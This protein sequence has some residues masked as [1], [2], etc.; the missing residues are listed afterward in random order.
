MLEW[1]IQVRGILSILAFRS[2]RL[3]SILRNAVKVT[4]E[5]V[6]FQVFVRLHSLSTGGKRHRAVVDDSDLPIEAKRQ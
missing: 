4:K 6:L 3:L 2:S 1:S 5:A